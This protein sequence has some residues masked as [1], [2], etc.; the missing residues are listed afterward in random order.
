MRANTALP[1]SLLAAIL[2]SGCAYLRLMVHG[3][4]LRATGNGGYECQVTQPDGTVGV[5]IQNWSLPFP[6]DFILPQYPNS[7]CF[8]HT[9]DKKNEQVTFESVRLAS[10][11]PDYQG[12]YAYYRKWFS[13][14]NWVISK[15]DKHFGLT[16]QQGRHEATVSC[17][18]NV[19]GNHRHY[20]EITLAFHPLAIQ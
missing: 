7:Q 2:L 3:D 15:D 10:S 13:N 16:A 4:Y 17:T 5:A 12:V 11:D 18:R 9:T 20:T 14:N 6:N 19:D 8:N 1:I